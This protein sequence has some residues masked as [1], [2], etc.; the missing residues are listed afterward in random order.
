MAEKIIILRNYGCQF[1]YINL[2]KGFNSRL[3]EIQA[4]ILRVKL[5]YLN[6]DNAK[7]REIAK[8]YI[9]NIN[10]DKI[11]LPQVKTENSHV[12]H[13]FVI[14]TESR[15]NLQ[16]YLIENGVQTLIHYPVPPHK[17]KAYKECNHLIYFALKKF[18]VKF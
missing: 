1:K 5:R 9:E 7:R 16:R 4:A 17:Q 13:L 11:I 14:R 10:N 2:V 8:Y 3:D 12:W 6:E 15:D 18:T